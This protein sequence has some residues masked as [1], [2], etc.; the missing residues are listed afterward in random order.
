MGHG[1]PLSASAQRELEDP[2]N[3]LLVS[4]VVALEIAIKRGLGKLQAPPDLVARLLS[5]D[6][7]RL[8]ISIEHAASVEHLPF[9]HRDPFD[10]LLI[11]QALS[12]SAS[13]VTADDA[14]HAYDVPI[15]W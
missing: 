6:A 4:A 9:H 8:A 15:L 11:A 14:M 10:R 3:Q 13:L 1:R 2:T 5:T 12:E 7:V